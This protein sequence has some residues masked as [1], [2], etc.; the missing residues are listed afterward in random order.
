[1]KHLAGK[2]HRTVCYSFHAIL[3][4]IFSVSQRNQRFIWTIHSGGRHSTGAPKTVSRRAWS[5]WIHCTCK[6]TVPQ[7]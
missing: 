7:V 6:W 5:C 3:N 1:M 2:K 4:C